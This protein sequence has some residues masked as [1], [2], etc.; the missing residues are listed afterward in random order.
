[1]SEKEPRPPAPNFPETYSES[2][3][4]VVS[5]EQRILTTDVPPEI[6]D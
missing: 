2:E 6:K 3:A 4:R 1:M 5:A